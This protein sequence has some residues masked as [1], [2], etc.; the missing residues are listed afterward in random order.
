MTSDLVLTQ[1]PEGRAPFGIVANPSDGTVFAAY[2]G[3]SGIWVGRRDGDGL[4]ELGAFDN[5]YT[6]D[7]RYL[8]G[9]QWLDAS[10]LFW[11]QRMPDGETYGIRLAKVTDSGW[12]PGPLTGV[13]GLGGNFLSLTPKNDGIAASFLFSSG[14]FPGDPRPVHQL[15][16][17][18]ATEVPAVT[19]TDLGFLTSEYDTFGGFLSRECGFFSDG[20]LLV[21]AA[22][23]MRKRRADGSAGPVINMAHQEYD[24]AGSFQT[25]EVFAVGA[26]SW[27]TAPPPSGELVLGYTVGDRYFWCT[28]TKFI[29]EANAE[30]VYLRY[31]LETGLRE[32]F[33][34]GLLGGNW[35]YDDNVDSPHPGQ[36][37]RLDDTTFWSSWLTSTTTED[38]SLVK[39]YVYVTF[40]AL[41][42]TATVRAVTDEPYTRLDGIPRERWPTSP[43]WLPGGTSPRT[44]RPRPA[45]PSTPPPRRRRAP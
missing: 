31:D 9:L 33:S 3:F 44:V 10:T 25:L 41:T 26:Q 6:D 34:T 36:T 17:G 19:V 35:N 27:V 29:D 23:T 15:T 13:T 28:G 20:G 24:V 5:G 11:V 45:G 21:V 12:T 4:V 14:V 38:G 8:Q 43:A 22:E 16:V 7:S 32:I 18:F 42:L 40:D 30:A 37:G 2:T 39:S 1:P